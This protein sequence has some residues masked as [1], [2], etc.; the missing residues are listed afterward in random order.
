MLVQHDSLLPTHSGYIPRLLYCPV[1]FPKEWGKPG[2]ISANVAGVSLE[3]RTE[4]LSNTSLDI[5]LVGPIMTLIPFFITVGSP[6][7]YF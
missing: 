4:Y 3:I 7:V 1:V 5:C 6:I 2:E